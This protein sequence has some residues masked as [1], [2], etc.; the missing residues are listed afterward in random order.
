L[1]AKQ[2][3]IQLNGFERKTYGHWEMRIDGDDALLLMTLRSIPAAMPVVIAV[4][5]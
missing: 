3:A 1:A 5:P 4:F 2:Q